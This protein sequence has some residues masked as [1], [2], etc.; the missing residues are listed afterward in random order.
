MNVRMC[1]RQITEI[2]IGWQLARDKHTHR[3]LIG[4]KKNARDKFVNLGDRNIVD[5]P[6]GT[7]IAF[8]SL[9]AAGSG[10]SFLFR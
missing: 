2:G 9:L 1:R 10:C 6:F 5:L 4:H 7:L 8:E 3:A